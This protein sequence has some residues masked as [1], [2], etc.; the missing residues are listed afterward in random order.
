MPKVMEDYLHIKQFRMPSD[1]GMV[2]TERPGSSSGGA[3]GRRQNNALDHEGRSIMRRKRFS[4]ILLDLG[5][6]RLLDATI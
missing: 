5:S 3:H 6:F 2:T 4:I 1:A